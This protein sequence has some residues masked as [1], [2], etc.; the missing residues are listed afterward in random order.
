MILNESAIRWNN[1]VRSTA[2]N[3]GW[4]FYEQTL[5][6]Q[7]QHDPAVVLIRGDRVILAYLRSGRPRTE[8][9][10]ARFAGVAG[11]E[12]YVWHPRDRYD[13]LRVLL[14]GPRDAGGPLP[15]AAG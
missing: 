5:R 11:V 14:A 7:R 15:P 1:E 2:L 3:H 10:V 9:P 12:V 6:N 4:N 8:P 13:M